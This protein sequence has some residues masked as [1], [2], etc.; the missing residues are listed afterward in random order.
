MQ[1]VNPIS[2]NVK[3][4]LQ[5]KTPVIELVHHYSLVIPK[6]GIPTLKIYKFVYYILPKEKFVRRRD[7]KVWVSRDVL[8]THEITVPYTTKTVTRES[9]Y[10]ADSY[11][12]MDDMCSTSTWEEQEIIYDQKKLEEFI[13]TIRK[14]YEHLL[15]EPFEPTNNP[16]HY[17]TRDKYIKS[18]W[19]ITD[20]K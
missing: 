16:I 9:T 4:M 20:T 13:N 15:T 7:K 12:Q 11:F 18:I 6:S 3:K 8:G 2:P 19:K 10:Y 17:Q 14:Q 5:G 1:E